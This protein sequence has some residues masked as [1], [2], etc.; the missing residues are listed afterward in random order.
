[1]WT[2]HLNNTDDQFESLNCMKIMKSLKYTNH[3]K[4]FLYIF[5]I[6]KHSLYSYKIAAE[7]S[8]IRKYL[9]SFYFPCVYKVVLISMLENNYY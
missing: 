5:K 4:I 2:A 7:H 6:R 3:K 1:M 9:K 8:L